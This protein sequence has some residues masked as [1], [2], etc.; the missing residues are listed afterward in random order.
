LPV[1]AD[2][3]LAGVT[4]VLTGTLSQPRAQI[5]EQIKAAGGIVQDAVTKQTRYLVAGGN[6]GATKTNKARAL[7]T[8]VVDEAGLLALLAGTATPS[9]PAPEAPRTAPEPEDTPDTPYSQQE[10]F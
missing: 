6:V 3:P 7:G 9:A 5:A 1:P 8:T 10:L 2:A 4:F